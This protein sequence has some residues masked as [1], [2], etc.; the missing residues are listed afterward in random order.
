[1]VVTEGYVAREAILGVKQ[2]NGLWLTER[3]GNQS[4][5]KQSMASVWLPGTQMK[6]HFVQSGLSK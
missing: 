6:E 3:I 1:M 2:H 5:G 4:K